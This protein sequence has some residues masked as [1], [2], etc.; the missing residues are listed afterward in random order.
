[1]LDTA[2]C[3]GDLQGKVAIVTGASAGIGKQ[4][5]VA[6]AAAGMK[7]VA[8]ARRKQK[9]EEFMTAALAEGAKEESLMTAQCDVQKESDIKDVIRSIEVW[10]SA[11]DAVQDISVM[12]WLSD[13]HYSHLIPLL[14]H[15]FAAYWVHVA[16]IMLVVE[17]VTLEVVPYLPGKKC[18]FLV[19]STWNLPP[20]VLINNAGLS[21]ED[22]TMLEGSTS[23]WQEMMNT[24]VIAVAV[25][26]REAVAAMRKHKSYGHIVNISSMSAYRIPKF[27]GGGFYA[28]TKHALRCISDGTRIEAQQQGIPLRVSCVSPGVVHT[29]F[30]HVRHKGNRLAAAEAVNYEA[31]ETRNVVQA[32]LYAVSAPKQVCV[33]DIVLRS[34]EQPL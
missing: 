33:D 24:N 26:S 27:A 19:Q 22:T 28:A 25:F 18:L 14:C 17:D 8:C 13:L 23:S 11:C 7:V 34:L 6:L 31:L 30:Y 21:L 4:C 5:A 9:L 12:L 15:F 10:I 29:D 20:A 3:L 32:V 1:M 16:V 2:P